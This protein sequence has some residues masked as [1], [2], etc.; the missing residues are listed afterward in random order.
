MSNERQFQIVIDA[1]YNIKVYFVPCFIPYFKRTNGVGVTNDWLDDGL[2]QTICKLQVESLGKILVTLYN[3]YNSK[4]CVCLE[5]YE[6]AVSVMFR[7][8]KTNIFFVQ[9]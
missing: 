4:L 8:C 9:H 1:E 7:F 2:A 5:K 3:R 6:F